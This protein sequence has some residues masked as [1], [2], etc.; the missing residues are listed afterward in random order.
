MC[1]GDENNKDDVWNPYEFFLYLEDD[2]EEG[3]EDED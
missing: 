3:S 1:C 2:E